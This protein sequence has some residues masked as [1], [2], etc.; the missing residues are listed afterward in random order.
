M[1]TNRQLREQS[2]LNLQHQCVDD[3]NS[4]T[5][6]DEDEITVNQRR[7]QAIQVL[8]KYLEDSEQRT[9][10]YAFRS[11]LMGDFV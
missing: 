8:V 4:I 9:V 3:L 2:V 5:L 6:L 1:T 11:A 10:A 7:D